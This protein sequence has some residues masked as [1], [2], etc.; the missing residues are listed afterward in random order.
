MLENTLPESLAPKIANYER[1]NRKPI[2]AGEAAARTARDFDGW[3]FIVRGRSRVAVL[4]LWPR[5][6][7]GAALGWP[8]RHRFDRTVAAIAYSLDILC[9]V[10]GWRDWVG[11]SAVRR[12]SASIERN[13]FAAHQGHRCSTHLRNPR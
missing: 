9:H 12:A 4:S 10:A 6:D 5:L 1:R 3:S 8:D 11:P 13:L 2:A 7:C